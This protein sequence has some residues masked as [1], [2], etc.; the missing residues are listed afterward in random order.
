VPDEVDP[1]DAE[2]VEDADQVPG[3][4][5]D[6]VALQVLRLVRG[7]E[8]A[9]V[10]GDRLISGG[11]QRGHL[12]PPARVGVGKTVHQ[13]DCRALPADLHLQRDAVDLDA[14]HTTPGTKILIMMLS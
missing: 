2:P 4:R 9:Q 6:L 7:A 1:V 11:V 12:V 10:R 8:P 13:Q 14:H 5:G 3:I